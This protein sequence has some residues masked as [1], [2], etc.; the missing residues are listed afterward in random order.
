MSER[1]Q[2][3]AQLAERL[4]A[5]GWRV[6]CAESCTGGLVAAACTDLA[7]SSDWFERGVVSYSNAAKVA[8][9]GVPQSLIEAH[10]AVSDAVARAMVEGIARTSGADLAVSVTGIAGPGG[11]TPTKPVGTVWFGFAVRRRD[12]TLQVDSQHRRFDGDRAEVRAASV[13]HALRG[14]LQRAQLM[15]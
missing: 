1:P 11:A 12:G 13:D 7:G 3:V 15:P 2:L 5:L 9:L 10:G 6:A 4:R 8:L 14:L